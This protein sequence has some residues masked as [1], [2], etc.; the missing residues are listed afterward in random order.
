MTTGADGT[1]Q[2]TITQPGTGDADGDQ[3][4][5]GP[6]L[7]D[8]HRVR[9]AGLLRAGRTGGGDADGRADRG[10]GHAGAVLDDPRH[11]GEAGLPQAPQGAAD[12]AGDGHATPARS[13]RWRC[14]SRAGA[15]RSARRSTTRAGRFV[16]AKCGRH[17]R[18]GVGT[19]K[20]V[21]FLLPQRL[22][23]GRYVFDVVATDAAG[24][25][26]AARPRAQ[27]GGVHGPVTRARRPPR[28]SS[29]PRPRTARSCSS[30]AAAATCCTARTPST[31]RA[32]RVTVAGHR[33]TV[34]ARTPLAAL[35][36]SRLTLKLRD[37]GACSRRARDAS[38]LYVRGVGPPEG[39]R[40]GRLGL[41][42]R[43]RD[44]VVRRGRP[45]LAHARAGAVVLVR[46]RQ[47]RLPADARRQAARRGRPRP[48]PCS[49]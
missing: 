37:Y 30:S 31:P 36:D 8:R 26:G 12:A 44:A 35:L 15:G 22:G 1:A 7:G 46:E 10:A 43:Q 45:R 19:D 21:S 3:G 9:P 24:N 28:C 49:R 33:C 42:G 41:Q 18:F 2:L 38:G 25:R 16:K 14:R 29:S 5:A 20:T 11:Q 23:R 17:P 4:Q 34:G 6:R 40:P 13:A 27:P 47:A 48:A 39:A 32:Q